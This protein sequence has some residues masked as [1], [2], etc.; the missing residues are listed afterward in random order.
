MR[1]FKLYKSRRKALKL[2]LPCTLFVLTGIFLLN[3]PHTSIFMSWSCILFF[4]LGVCMGLFQLVDR[5]PQIILNDLGI[6]DRTLHS[7]FINWEIIYDAYIVGFHKQ[8][9]ICLVVDEHFEPS[10]TK[11][12]FGQKMAI[13]SKKMGFQELNIN[14][15]NVDVDAEKLT[16]LI[17]A[18]RNADMP[19]REVLLKK[20]LN[21]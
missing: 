3:R 8:Q 13:L 19:D 15:G 17:L 4:G 6:F 1:E 2:I 20:R 7:S 16:M 14:V 11:G 21:S 5:R 10:Q 9:F 18:M 12:K